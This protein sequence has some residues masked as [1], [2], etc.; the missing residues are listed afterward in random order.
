MP[1]LDFISDEILKT[2]LERDYNELQNCLEH[3][4]DKS[5]ILLAGSI[6]EAILV[7]CFLNFLPKGKKKKDILKA[8]LSDLISW[9]FK[10]NLISETTRDLSSAVR[11]YRNLIH[12]GREYRQKQKVSNKIATVSLNLV[13]IILEEISERY[14]EKRGYTSEQAIRKL[15]ND[16]TSITIIDHIIKNMSEG[17]RIKLFCEIPLLCFERYD[18]RIGIDSTSERFINAHNK[19][20]K[21]VPKEILK[22]EVTKLY[23]FVTNGTVE[24]VLF[25]LVFFHRYL[26]VID[27]D[28]LDAI[29]DYISGTLKGGDFWLI[30]GFRKY[31]IYFLGKYFN[32]KDRI[33]QFCELCMDV[34]IYTNS[35][36]GNQSIECIKDIFFSMN[37]KNQELIRDEI[38]GYPKAFSSLLLEHFKEEELPF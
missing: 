7:D 14:S 22:D 16:P 15:E 36:E 28:K 8:S 30:E 23:N 38:K 20:S 9:A 6:I 5:T 12:P 1:S 29:L 25:H 17:E 19:L 10:E 34:E 26:D 24:E 13:E 32:N 33:S 27:K 2:M 18:S 11:Q 21:Y 37:E 35:P 4:L 31:G 3:G